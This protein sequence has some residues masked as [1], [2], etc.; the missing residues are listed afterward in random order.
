MRLARLNRLIAK[1][2]ALGLGVYLY[3][4]E[5]RTLPVSCGWLRG[6]S[7]I[8]AA[9]QPP[10]G[11]WSAGP[12]GSVLPPVCAPLLRPTQPGLWIAPRDRFH[13][14][15]QIG[16]QACVCV[17]GLFAASARPA[18]SARLHDWRFAEFLDSPNNRTSRY[19][20]LT[21]HQSSAPKADRQT[22]RSCD[23]PPH[24]LVEK[25]SQLFESRPD[26]VHLSHLAEYKKLSEPGGARP[27]L[28]RASP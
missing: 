8:H 11:D 19:T 15:F 7:P 26:S 22:L 20:R 4:N 2:D 5:P 23:Q 6:Y 21:R 1:C 13:Q 24:T 25:E 9:T 27:P 3:L 14:T 10:S 18:H 17:G 12:G 28:E 16:L